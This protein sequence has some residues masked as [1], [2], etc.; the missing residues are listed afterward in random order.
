MHLGQRVREVFQDQD[1]PRAG[2]VQLVL[3][4]ARRVHRVRVDDRESGTERAEDRDG[5]LQHVGQ[6]QR[7]A[8]TLAQPGDLLQV[9]REPAGEH[10]DVAI[11]QRAVHAGEAR[12]VAM[13]R[14]GLL[15]QLEQRAILG[16]IDFGRHA[17]RVMLQPDLVQDGSPG[18]CARGRG[19]GERHPVYI[20]ARPPE[21]TDSRSAEIGRRYFRAS[22][23]CRCGQTSSSNRGWAAAVGWMPSSWNRASS[24]A[25][26][27]EQERH[28]RQ[29]VLLRQVA[30]HAVEVAGIGGAVVGR[31][32]HAD[33]QNPRARLLRTADDGFEVPADVGDGE[34]AQSVV[35]AQFHDDDRRPMRGQCPGQP[36]Q[37]AARGLAARTGIDD[38]VTV[39]F[40]AQPS[41]QQGH[42]A[43]LNSNSITR[44]EAVA[45]DQ[46]GGGGRRCVRCTGRSGRA[47][48]KQDEAQDTNGSE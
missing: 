22:I 7:D 2:I 27:C 43:L 26:S 37:R 47:A 30:I 13:R 19:R 16:R 8:V 4:F 18:V 46:D 10:V 25:T 36:G 32:L 11:G 29:L 28:A 44:A 48:G 23:G 1:R 33:Q 38:A 45:Q 9:G 17:G 14:D 41:L 21:N 20:T 5:V 6:H 39:P 40:G 35:A 34:A 12:P 3:Q 31:N 15:D 42:P 24:G